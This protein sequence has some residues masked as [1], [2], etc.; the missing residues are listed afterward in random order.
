MCGNVRCVHVHAD[1]CT[2]T[3]DTYLGLSAD[4]SNFIF[5]PR[6]SLA[7]LELKDLVEAKEEKVKQDLLDPKE[8]L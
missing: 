1:I 7:T 3:R 8:S 2:R 5:F 6:E 4:K